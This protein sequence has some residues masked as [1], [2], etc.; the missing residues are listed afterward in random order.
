MDAELQLG[1]PRVG[2]RDAELGLGGPRVGHRNAELELGGP[3]VGGAG[4][5]SSEDGGRMRVGVAS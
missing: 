2:H 4:V 3:R 1:G 5:T